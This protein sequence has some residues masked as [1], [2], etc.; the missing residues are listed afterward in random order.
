[1]IRLSLS[2]GNN[3]VQVPLRLPTNPGEAGSVFAQLDGISTRH[4]TYIQNIQ[5]DVPGLLQY[6]RNVDIDSSDGFAKLN[7]LAKKIQAMTQK[8]C[9]IFSGALDAQSI[10]GI[11]DVL[12]TA[13]KLDSYTLIP[14]VTSDTELGLYV[15]EE[16]FLDMPEQAK[17]YLDYTGIGKKFYSELGGAYTTAGYVIRADALNPTKENR[18]TAVSLAV[19]ANGK[20]VRLSLPA[21][22]NELEAAM[23]ELGITS[24]DHANISKMEIHVP[25]LENYLPVDDNGICIEDANELAQAIEELQQRD[26]E[27]LKYLS[28]LAVVEP[29][30]MREALGLTM[31]L[32][33][34]ERVTEDI[35]EYGKSVLRR[36]GA[37]EEL[38]REISCYMD[39]A[40]FGEDSMMQD[41]VKRTEFG[42]IRRLGD[43]ISEEQQGMEFAGM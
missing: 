33:N 30:T 25:Y 8:E 36:H 29:K 10:M 18:F 5:C 38:I 39:L 32:H 12:R 11:D 13:D 23:R 2:R 42:L 21:E 4:P 14:K 3:P 17:P 28:V 22:D 31:E 41:G 27:M 35:A 43:S 9:I 37:S 24:F 19:T 26:G 16:G 20:L 34:Y 15:V 6:I 1:M 7:E 40:F